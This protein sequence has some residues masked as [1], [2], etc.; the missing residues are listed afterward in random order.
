MT[1]FK[2]PKRR[3]P[4]NKGFQVTHYSKKFQSSLLSVEVGLVEKEITCE[5]PAQIK[6]K[7][8]QGIAVPEAPR[9]TLYHSYI[10]DDRE[11]LTK[12]DVITPSAQ[13]IANMNKGF[14]ALPHSFAGESK[15]GLQVKIKMVT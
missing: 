8:S 9:G 6:P 13:N 1:F 10:L 4:I 12:A 15:D 11:R 2:E 7:A 3:I 5:K 14:R